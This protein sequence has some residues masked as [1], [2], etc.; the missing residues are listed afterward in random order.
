[1]TKNIKGGVMRV[2]IKNENAIKLKEFLQNLDKNNID[3]DIRNEIDELI[4]QI[5]NKVGE[6][7][8]KR[9][10]E[11]MLKANKIRQER[12]KEKIINALNM[13]LLEGKNIT[14]YQ[15]AKFSGVS[16]NTIHKNYR[17]LIEKYKNMRNS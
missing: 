16:Y 7:V 9:K 15:V 13:L 10:K 8:S 17:D 4:K 12:V 14:M 6:G 2:V 1:L 5:N 11:A 3:T